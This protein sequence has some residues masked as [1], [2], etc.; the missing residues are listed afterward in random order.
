MF[1]QAIVS[2]FCNKAHYVNRI[3]ETIYLYSTSRKPKTVP[4]AHAK[5]SIRIPTIR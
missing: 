1:D 4:Y 2:K 5:S 3:Q